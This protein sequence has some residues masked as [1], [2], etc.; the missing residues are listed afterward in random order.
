MAV[1][2][3]TAL[4]KTLWILAAAFALTAGI[5]D[6]RWQKIPN[7]LTYPAVP[8][9]ILLHWMIAGNHAALLSLAG[10][11]LGLGILLP[12]VLLGGLGGGDWKLVGALGFFFGPQRLVPILLLTLMINGIMA[13]ALIL[14]KRRLGQTFRNLGHMTVALFRF[15]SPGAEELTID[16]PETAKVPFGIAAAIAVLLYVAA[17][18]WTAF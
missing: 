9:A 10:A 5:T 7:W 3:R 17:Q 14:W 12:F 18:P 16:N 11:A 4:A 1:E 15:R 6:L 13:I 2:F 8:I